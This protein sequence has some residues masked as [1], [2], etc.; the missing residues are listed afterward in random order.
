V[1]AEP[2]SNRKGSVPFLTLAGPP[3]PIGLDRLSLSFPIE[4][5]DS[6]RFYTETVTRNLDG[7]R[8][9]LGT[10]EDGCFIGAMEIPERGWVGK[11]E[12]NPSRFDDPD[13][14]SLLPV[15]QAHEAACRMLGVASTVVQLRTEPASVRVKRADLARDFTGSTDPGFLIRGLGGRRRKHARRQFTYSDPQRGNAETLFVG[16]KS[17]GVRLYD[18]HEAYADKGAPAGAIR[19]EVEARAAWL[20]SGGVERVGD[21][22]NVVALRDYA[23][24]RWAWSEMGATVMGEGALVAHLAQ[25]QADGEITTSEAHRVLGFMY[26]EAQGFALPQSRRTFYRLRSIVRSHGLYL[27]IGSGP[28]SKRLDWATGVEIAC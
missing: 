28:A 8:V 3:A 12:A 5:P 6:S 16:S 14:C 1:T 13:G 25:L 7:P 2:P 4:R 10:M 17:G 24:E 19:W 26:C 18:Q 9:S 15:E 20:A 21:L 22:R 27:S 23:A 11:V